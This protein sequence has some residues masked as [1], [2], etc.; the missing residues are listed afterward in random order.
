VVVFI[1]VLARI[2]KT[3]QLSIIGNIYTEWSGI[4]DI[5]N[6]DDARLIDDTTIINDTQEIDTFLSILFGISSIF[7]PVN[8]NRIDSHGNLL[9]PSVTISGSVISLK[10]TGITVPKTILENQIL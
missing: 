6:I 2:D 10:N 1:T 3:G 8:V 5:Q 9:T 4:D 7:L